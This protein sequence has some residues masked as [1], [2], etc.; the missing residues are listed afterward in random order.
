MTLR[1][2]ARLIGLV[3]ALVSLVLL[4]LLG[5]ASQERA[6]T[7]R[8]LALADALAF[9]TTQLRTALF[10]YL[11]QPQ[12]QTRAPVAAQFRVLDDLLERTATRALRADEQTRYAWEGARRLAGGLGEHF[13][14]SGDTGTDQRFAERDRRTAELMLMD[15]HSLILFVRQMRHRANARFIAAGARVN[16]TLV[17]LVAVM[18]VLGLTLFVVFG[19]SVLA[20]LGQLRATALRIAGGEPDLRLHSRRADELGELANAF[21][22]MLDQLAATRVSRDRLEAEMAERQRAESEV[23]RLNAELEVRVRQRTAE[24]ESANQELESFAYAVSHDLRAPLRALSGF[25]QA[26]LEDYAERLDGEARVF[27]DQIGS[28]SRRMGELIDGI[29]TLSRSTRGELR[30]DPVDLSTLAHRLLSERARAEPHRQVV[31]EVAPELCV[32]GDP[33]MLEVVMVNLID[34]AWK[35]TAKTPNATIRVTTEDRA[36][37]RWLC[38]ADNGAG[39]DMAYA[40]RLFQPFQRL[41]RQDEFPGIGIG[42]ATVQRIIHRHGGTIEAAGTP[43]GGATF[44]FTLPTATDCQEPS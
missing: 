36:G 25:S 33:T 13:A 28:A 16:L 41:H 43:G 37:K 14:K 5:I 12:S 8:D 44:R 11:L 38:V 7:E 26:L 15:T 31:W 40:E 32:A 10:G 39:F 4:G 3:S 18:S 22:R 27:L 6:R 35:Y 42:L 24:L 21:D 23:L 17:V 19:R 1:A 34:N 29:L 20:P 9:E 30:R 2:R